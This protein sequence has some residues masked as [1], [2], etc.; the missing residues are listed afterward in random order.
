MTASRAVHGATGRGAGGRGATRWAVAARGVPWRD[1][2]SGVGRGHRG[3]TRYHRG[4]VH[5]W[6]GSPTGRPGRRRC[7]LGAA[8]LS[9]PRRGSCPVG[10][11]RPVHS[12]TYRLLFTRPLV[13]LEGIKTAPHCGS[14]GGPRSGLQIVYYVFLPSPGYVLL[15][16]PQAAS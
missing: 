14:N 5:G 15:P 3:V 9:P 8:R 12:S 2:V 11:P 16:V 6:P 7:G 10:A 13:L 4:G 1:G